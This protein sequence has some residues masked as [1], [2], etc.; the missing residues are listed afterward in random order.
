MNHQE[1]ID[2]HKILKMIVGSKAYGTDTP[3]SDT[4]Y[5]GVF[6]APKQY[7]FG[8]EKIEEVDLSIV[9]KQIDG[10]NDSDAVDCKFYELRNYCKLLLEN[11]PNIVD[12]IF[13][14]DKHVTY[15]NNFGLMLRDN[16]HMFLHSGLKNR[17]VGYAIS[18]LHK[19]RIKTDNYD[20]LNK[21]ND[22]FAQEVFN[23]PNAL[24]AEYKSDSSFLKF[25]TF[26]THHVTIGD[27]NISIKDSVTKAFNKIAERISKVGNR[28][29][30]YTKYGYD[31]KFL[32][33]AYRLVI[34]GIELM[35]T[36]DLQLPITDGYFIKDIKC[37]KH[38]PEDIIELVECKIKKLDS[39]ESVLPV[40]PRFKEVNDL[41][42]NM[43]EESF[44]K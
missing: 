16:R 31:T 40:K 43:V 33:H 17:F 14:S 13:V 24:L 41:L 39:C 12:S 11:N 32:S 30:L 3:V 10:R 36:G 20:S 22:W 2:N 6:I 7:Y 5:L 15:K 18:Q 28:K 21:A 9:S 35:T 29:E 34:E 19:A 1:L 25:A 42:I 37:G 27:I 38:K 44:K 23:N 8:L 26:N 4:D